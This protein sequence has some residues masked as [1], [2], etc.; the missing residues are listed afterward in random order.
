MKKFNDALLTGGIQRALEVL[1]AR[2]PHRFTAAY[3]FDAQMMRSEAFIDKEGGPPILR[4][5]NVDLG[6]SFCQYTMRDGYFLTDNTTDDDRLDGHLA[7]G[8]ILSY[9]GVPL[10]DADGKPFGSLCHYD[11]VIRALA[12]R[13]FA[14]MKLAAAALSTFM[15]AGGR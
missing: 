12:V 7:Q 6:H 8:R 1:N 2:V 4:F 14:Y 9:H 15:L 3:R 10:L 13:E 5:L 11:T